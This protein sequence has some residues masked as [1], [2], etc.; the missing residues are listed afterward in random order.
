MSKSMKRWS[1]LGLAGL[2]TV[3]LAACG[4]TV[5]EDT[6]SRS[7]G[8]EDFEGVE[9]ASEISFWSNHPGNSIEM[10]QKFAADFEDET[11]IKVNIVSAGA[12]YDEVLQKYQTAQ[13]S[14]D[15]GDLVVV[16]DYTWFQGYLNDSI[17][18]VDH[19]FEAAGLDTSTYTPG[20]FED[21]LYE[22]SHYA[23]PY[24]RSTLVYYY[25]KDYFKQAGIEADGAKTLAEAEEYAK[26]IQAAG[27]DTIPYAFNP[28]VAHASWAMTA[29]VW[30]NGGNW[31]DGWDF[32]P[33]TDPA[34]VETLEWAQRGVEE[35]WGKVFSGDASTAF[36][37]GATA[38]M[39]NSSGGLGS[40][41]ESVDFEVG[42]GLVPLGST[43]D[44]HIVPSGGCGVAINANTTPEKQLAAA[45]FADYL[46]NAQ[47]TVEFSAATGYLPVRTDADAE[48]L[49][50][51]EPLFQVA[52]DSL[53]YVRPQTYARVLLPDGAL[54]LDEGIMDILVNKADVNS[55][56]ESMRSEAEQS[57]QKNVESVVR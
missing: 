53:D 37:S 19:V 32:A 16:A 26:A 45:M 3:S 9:P 55:T 56:L 23:V 50:K 2:L 17:L 33:M 30:A 44:Q 27:I 15:A 6:Q 54:I 25:N 11:G 48:Q 7:Y 21:Y 51:D 34:T 20:F 43:G 12:S 4:P 42:V 24:G 31:S 8:S 52:L 57:Y 41:Q 35:G 49:A 22:G 1:A 40:I 39:L 29:L 36:A 18:P 47:N 38:Q 13:A 28:D 46:T 5:G 14:N 10:E